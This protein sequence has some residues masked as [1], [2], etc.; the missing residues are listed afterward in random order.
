VPVTQLEGDSRSSSEGKGIR[1]FSYKW[2]KS[3]S[4][5]RTFGI[6]NTLGGGGSLGGS[7]FSWEETKGW[8]QLAE[9]R[10]IVIRLQTQDETALCSP[11]K[12]KKLRW[13]GKGT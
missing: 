11:G 3:K 8:F 2:D 1:T 10:A 13:G 6:H 12:E 4:L 9:Q 5:R 7:R